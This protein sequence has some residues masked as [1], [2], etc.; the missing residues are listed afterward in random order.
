MA[1]AKKHGTAA[2]A[3]D[4]HRQLS[5]T[6]AGLPCLVIVCGVRRMASITSLNR[7]RQRWTDPGL[8][9]R[10]RPTTAALRRFQISQGG[11][12]QWTGIA[13]KG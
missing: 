6:T 1:L 5:A 13:C 4:A 12:S 9:A 8:L 3:T 7:A 2:G 11:N 10:L